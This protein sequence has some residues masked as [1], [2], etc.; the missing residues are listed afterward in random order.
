MTAVADRALVRAR[1]AAQEIST[2]SEWSPAAIVR[3]MTA[4]QAQDVPSATW[5][6]GVRNPNL[7]L[8]DV[9]RAFIEG[10]I[11]RSWPM[12]GT[13][14][15]VA[16]EDLRWILALTSERL[17]RGSLARRTALGLGEADL[18]HA[19]TAAHEA[20]TGGR[21]LPRN[22]MYRV[23]DH[24]GVAT[25]GQR[26]YHILWFLSQTGTVIFGP[27]S[28]TTQ[29]FALLDEWA[30]AQRELERDEALG[31][32]V[33]RYFRSH[34]PA[35][36]RDFAWWSSTTLTEARTGLALARHQLDTVDRDG[37]PLY[38]AAGTSPDLPRDGVR[39]LPGFDEY[40]LGYRDRTPQLPASR[41]DDIVPG[42]NG[43][44]RGTVVEDGTVVG[45][46]KRG[47]S[48]TGTALDIRM[49]SSTNSR[50][51]RGISRAERD[52]SAFLTGAHG[53][54]R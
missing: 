26:G 10:S 53:R 43:V 37:E 38:F 18:E 15:V 11:V 16:P 40:L 48:R 14:H 51:D 5:S 17:I 47:P 1:L 12:R 29:T 6:I 25:A 30:P 28:G 3:W 49:F 35:S 2:T 39:L 8:A 33:F 24:A 32:F 13:L 41:A 7:S 4:M 23:F 27:P 34:G 36:I 19:R 54:G 44:F 22:E 42:G 45:S 46:W 9:N 31:E 50:I 21:S 52:Y 20:L